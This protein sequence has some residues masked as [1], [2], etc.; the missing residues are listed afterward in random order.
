MGEAG[1]RILKPL[2]SSGV[3]IGLVEEVMLR[4]P[5]AQQGEAVSRPTR[6]ICDSM[7]LPRPPSRA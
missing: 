2:R 6:S 1:T 7:Y 3:W 5:L 4:K